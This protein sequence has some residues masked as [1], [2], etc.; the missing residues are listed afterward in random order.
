[1]HKQI[2]SSSQV[3]TRINKKLREQTNFVI[4]CR[5]FLGG[6]CVTNKFFNTPEYIANG[7]KMD[8]GVRKRRVKKRYCFVAFDTIRRQYN[9]E[10]ILKEL[11]TGKSSLQ[12]LADFLK[13]SEK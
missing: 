6:R 8:K 5:S 11:Q 10:E 13:E 1:M 9:T 4:E 12:Q 7:E 3:F 2:V